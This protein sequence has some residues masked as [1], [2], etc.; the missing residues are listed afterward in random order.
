M[1]KEKFALRDG[2]SMVREDKGMWLKSKLQGH[3]AKLYLTD[4]R[5]VVATTGIPALGLLGLM[6]NKE[7]TV[8]VTLSKGDVA[9]VEESKH[10]RA[11]NVL[12]V[13]SANGDPTR[14]IATAPFAEW[15]SAIDSWSE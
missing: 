10:G 3:S 14:F 13:N 6:F 15:K 1:A 5:L 8:R 11:K 7:G 9:G 12:Q 2:E 4:Q